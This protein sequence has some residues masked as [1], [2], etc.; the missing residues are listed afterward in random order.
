MD[1]PSS[2]KIIRNSAMLIAVLVISSGCE[3]TNTWLKGFT[4]RQEEPIIL[5]APGASTYLSDMYKLAGGDPATQAEIYADA[6]A[7]A[8]LSPG[9]MTNLRF[10]LVL[11]TPGHAETSG[12]AAQSM[13]RSLL[14]QPELMT[15][16]EVALATIHLQEVEARLVLDAETRRLR[17]ENTRTATTE[18]AA[19]E[20]A[21]ARRIANVEAENRRLQRSLDD[22]E[23]K[24]DALSAIERS[25]REQ[26]DNGDP[27]Q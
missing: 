12:I 3:A 1:K 19:V 17:S 20:A 4:T 14:A 6:E 22:A 27:P 24:L 9:T 18:E 13:L 11:A 26:S 15:P 23:S 2:T 7:A 5:G 10:A 25:L 21:V 8:R 16:G